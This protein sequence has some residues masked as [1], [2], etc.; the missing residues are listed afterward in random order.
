V[1]G[2]DAETTF[3]IGDLYLQPINLGWHTRRFEFMAGLGTFVPTGRYEFESD[4]NTGLGMWAFELFGVA[5]AFWQTH[6]EKED[7]VIS[8][9]DMFIFS[10]TVEF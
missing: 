2:L 4:G 1:L 10:L 6:T 3:A 9:G 8:V 5:L 7:S